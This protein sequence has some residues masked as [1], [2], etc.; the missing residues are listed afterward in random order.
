MLINIYKFSDSSVAIVTLET[1]SGT[2]E[3]NTNSYLKTSL[4]SHEEHMTTSDTTQSRN[5]D[6]TVVKGIETNDNSEKYESTTSET[7]MV[8][9][10]NNTKYSIT[11]SPST[12]ETLM[13]IQSTDTIHI[14][15][16]VEKDLTATRGEILY[17]NHMSTS[18]RKIEANDADSTYDSNVS[19]FSYTKEIQSQR[20]EISERLTEEMT[21]KSFP[22]TV[23]SA[24]SSEEPASKH[25]DIYSLNTDVTTLNLNTD[26]NTVERSSH[27]TRSVSTENL[28]DVEE[29]VTQR[30]YTS[31][32]SERNLSGSKVKITDNVMVTTYSTAETNGEYSEKS[33]TAT[34]VFATS[35]KLNNPNSENESTV[36]QYS[37]TT[38]PAVVTE[39]LNTQGT[40]QRDEM[41]NYESTTSTSASVM[42][43]EVSHTDS[44][45]DE[46]LLVN[47]I[48]KVPQYF[49]DVH[50]RNTLTTELTF[51]SPDDSNKAGSIP[52]SSSTTVSSQQTIQSTTDIVEELSSLSSTNTIERRTTYSYDK[53]SSSLQISDKTER[54]TGE[55]TE[56]F[57]STET[58]ISKEYYNTNANI[59]EST[60]N[61]IQHNTE[62][63]DKTSYPTS[64]RTYND[65]NIL[66]SQTNIFTSV[67]GSSSVLSEAKSEGNLAVTENS[68]TKIAS[69]DY[70]EN[71]DEESSPGEHH[72][73]LTT[74][75][76]TTIQDESDTSTP[77]TAPATNTANELTSTFQN[78]NNVNQMST[79]SF[80]AEDA[81]DKYLFTQRPGVSETKLHLDDSNGT[82]VPT[83]SELNDLDIVG[84]SHFLNKRSFEQ[85]TNYNNSTSHEQTESTAS[86]LPVHVNTVAA[87]T[88]NTN[89]S[90]LNEDTFLNE[91]MS[92]KSD[93]DYMV[94]NT[95]T[96]VQSIFSNSS[97]STSNTT[98]FEKSTEDGLITDIHKQTGTT[99][100]SETAKL[101]H[102]QSTL[103]DQSSVFQTVTDTNLN[104]INNSN[105]T[106]E[107][108]TLSAT[109]TLEVSSTETSKS[110]IVEDTIT[111]IS[112]DI[113]QTEDL[114]SKLTST[115]NEN[116]EV[117]NVGSTLSTVNPS[118]E[119]LFTEKSTNDSGTTLF[120][121][122]NSS[123][124][125]NKKAESSTHEILTEG[126]V[127][128]TTFETGRESSN[129]IPDES[130]DSTKD[131]SK[132]S[133]Q[134][135]VT[136]V[137]NVESST[138]SIKPST[139]SAI[140]TEPYQTSQDTN[141]IQEDKLT[142][143]S[144]NFVD[145]TTYPPMIETT[146]PHTHASIDMTSVEKDFY[147]VSTQQ[148][149]STSIN[150]Q[151]VSWQSSSKGESLPDETSRMTTVPVSTDSTYLNEDKFFTQTNIRD[152]VGGT[153]PDQVN[154]VSLLQSDV[155]TLLT[156]FR[157][158]TTVG[159]DRQTIS[160]VP[161]R[162]SS[163]VTTKGGLPYSSDH[164][165]TAEQKP[166][167]FIMAENSFAP[168]EMSSTKG[169]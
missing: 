113:T 93:V 51:T 86:T 97:A 154:G 169:K 60:P 137:P 75:H 121:E 136:D 24:K 108:F 90:N 158:T 142:S 164:T 43:E 91:Q 161:D 99:L 21:T 39:R 71:N 14:T 46:L 144:V 96:T 77:M 98:S 153:T 149:G 8:N 76:E 79:E 31:A 52:A 118:A 101:S 26:Q 107:T 78:S 100:A 94:T 35:E 44:S 15:D 133:T 162:S 70:H 57:E 13:E 47:T 87:T 12:T 61:E 147:K 131:D 20:S 143:S 9:D 41:S 56:N 10:A 157:D 25:K 33:T 156:N 102:N 132:K 82:V 150:A 68:F 166:S 16:N 3:V 38:S 85:P 83:S 69:A 125:E 120:D 23:E 119:L 106:P 27:A 53:T 49:T 81:E 112:P 45:K 6:K 62:T 66:S 63:V 139:K 28:T 114:F 11:D 36:T 159:I 163:E 22:T 40:M 103:A 128:T 165:D 65:N 140:I 88:E 1:H 105:S 135:F 64:T 148:F 117:P 134:G 160:K 32:T 92:S 34:T 72:K 80:R 141:S 48:S 5:T 59:P 129:L 89:I 111:T 123:K 74:T 155:F 116:S 126:A 73:E 18:T 145:I 167:T 84:T 29:S 4:S 146:R 50:S 37:K 30:V 110:A 151:D 54:N 104:F 19:T 109:Q 95:G 58:Y 67:I 152:D 138:Y 55:P 124:F 122:Q 17:T 168:T 2:S 127:H 130:I 115:I 42:N 7:T